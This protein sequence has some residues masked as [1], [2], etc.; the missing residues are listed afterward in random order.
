MIGHAQHHHRHG[1]RG[2]DREPHQKGLIGNLLPLILPCGG[3]RVWRGRSGCHGRSNRRVPQRA[4]RVMEGGRARDPWQILDRR[5]L[6][7][8]VN[9]GSDD[10]LNGL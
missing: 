9:R 2:G 4:N 10:T 5:L 1:Q 7:G 8:Q 6:G 3:L